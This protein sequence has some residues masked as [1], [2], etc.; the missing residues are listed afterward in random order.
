MQA[1][2]KDT[3]DIIPVFDRKKQV[4]GFRTI[5][6]YR[7]KE[8]NATAFKLEGLC[9][10]NGKLDLKQYKRLRSRL[11]SA[12]LSRIPAD[13][14]VRDVK[15]HLAGKCVSRKNP[16]KDLNVD[17]VVT[18]L[19]IDAIRLLNDSGKLPAGRVDTEFEW[20]SR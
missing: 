16:P 6:A 9:D 8:H 3:V 11:A 1:R 18:F 14:T 5:W 2:E 4:F 20:I 12:I 13:G 17:W 10:K 7:T 19:Q 15:V